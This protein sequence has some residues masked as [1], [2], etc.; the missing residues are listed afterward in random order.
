M[1]KKLSAFLFAFIAFLAFPFMAIASGDFT[2]SN[3]AINLTVGPATYSFDY[4]GYAGGTV[5]KVYISKAN[6]EFN[7]SAVSNSPT[8]SA[9]HC[10]GVF[11]QGLAAFPS[12]SDTYWLNIFDGSTNN[13]SQPLS[14]STFAGCSNVAPIVG[15]IS[16]STNP[17]QVNNSITASASFT[18][19]NAADTHTASW[20][21]GDGNTTTGTV[22]ESNG[23]GSVSNSHTYTTA[24]VYPITLTVTDNN[25]ASGSQTFKQ[26]SVYNPTAQGLFS[27]GQKYTSPTGAY[28]QNTNLTGT[29]RFGLS[30]KYQG[31]MPADN[32]QF[33]MDFNEANLHFNA[34]SISSLVIS[35]GIG[36][37]TGS[38]TLSGYSGSYNFLVTGSESAKTIRIQIKDSS[39]NVI[40]DTQPGAS[41]TATPTTSVTGQVLAH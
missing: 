29:V 32:R 15:T 16:L 20:N 3:V 40:Y 30:Y 7:A 35:N 10:S 41:D 22:T 6:D 18:D 19:T 11:D 1:F 27:A 28:L 2:A 21:W 24:G 31:T 23:S 13:F 14:G 4:S 33:S 5:T 26:L 38:G 39:N 9:G 12:C 37:L 36:T 8:C 34:T 17:I 25:G